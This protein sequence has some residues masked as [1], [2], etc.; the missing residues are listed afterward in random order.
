MAKV[1][2][3][4]NGSENSNLYPAFVLGA[5]A[6]AA[7][8]DV[9]IFF[10]PAGVPALKPGFL[11]GINAKGMPPMGELLD[12]VMALGGRMIL[13]ELGLDVHDVT[14]EDLRDDIEISGA[15]SFMALIQDATN[16]F[17]F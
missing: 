3:I 4:C 15:T 2:F 13:C 8:D 17:S 14:A 6:A 9:V 16:T 11:E 12:G 1:A 5:S 7:G 10:T